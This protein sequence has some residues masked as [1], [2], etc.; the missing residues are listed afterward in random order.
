MPSLSATQPGEKIL[1]YNIPD[2]PW[3]V[4]GTDMFTLNNKNYLCIVDYHSKFPIVKRAENMSAESLIIV[5]KVIFSECRLTKRIISY[6][7]DNFISDKFR[8]FCNCMNIKQVTP[9]SCYHQSNGQVEACIKFA[10]HTMK[11][12]VKTND[13]IHIALLQ[14]RATP[15]EPRL[16]S[17]ATLLFS[18]PMQGI[19]QII[20]RMP[21][22]S[23]NND[24]H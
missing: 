6:V 12:C 24:D 13:D 15:L 1:H 11:K 8:Q 17:P 21:I 14:I 3:E 7:G 2:K 23:D 20:N 5:C 18:C 9:S 19:M 16:P 10:K 4:K 22:N